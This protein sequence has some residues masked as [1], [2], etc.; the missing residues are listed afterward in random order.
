MKAYSILAAALTI[1]IACGGNEP[2]EGYTGIDAEVAQARSKRAKDS[3]IVL[4]DS[5]LQEK[6]RQLSFQSQLIGDAATSARLVSEISSDLSRARIEVKADTTRP[7]SAIQNASDELV[8]VQQKVKIVIDRLNASEA[9]LR[10]MRTESDNT[11]KAH[12]AALAQYEQSIADLRATVERQTME[13]ATLTTTVDSMAQVNVALNQHNDSITAQNVAMA[14]H[15]DS[16]FVAIGTEK[17]LTEKGIIR[18]EGGTLLAFGRGKTIV[19][20][21]ALEVEDFQVISKSQDVTIQLP[22]SDREYRIVSRQSLEF[23]DVSN[24]GE[25]MVKGALNVT[26]PE[27][28][29]EASKYLILV[30]R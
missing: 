13:I 17:E 16:V 14:A 19:P 26:N 12:A 20:A 28:F 29:W 25:P 1:A 24:P 9:R 8:V 4:K 7:E 22:E 27:K 30:R 5:L 2:P 21:R 3:L 15:E 23:T 11:A 6:E 18:R 10:R